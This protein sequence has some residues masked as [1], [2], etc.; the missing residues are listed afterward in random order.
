MIY[1]DNSAT[2]RPFDSVVEKMR[3]SMEE[4]YFNPS[5]MY[6]QAMQATDALKKARGLVSDALGGV[7]RVILTGGG[8]EADNLA[9]LGVAERLRGRKAGFITTAVEH[10]AVLECM[11]KLHDDGHEVYFAPVDASGVVDVDDLIAHVTDDT[12][13][14]SVM[15]VNNE[16]GALQPIE[17][18]AARLKE[19]NPR[20]LFHVDGVQ[21]FLRVPIHL[22]K[23]GV[24]LYSLSGHKIHGPKGVGALAVCGKVLLA[25]RLLGGGQEDGLRSGTENVPGIVGLS[26]AIENYPDTEKAAA[27]MQA[28]KCRLCEGILLAVPEA[29]LNGPDPLKGAPHILNL[30]FP[31]RGEVL[32]HALEGMGVLVSTGSACSSHKKAASHVLTAMGLEP[33]RLDGAVRFSLSVLNNEQEI[34]ETIRMVAQCVNSLKRFKRR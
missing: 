28:L 13:L 17:Q 15:Q 21:G 34:E 16:V 20:A 2:T 7:D 18:I 10:P 12:A 25:P 19:K 5:S 32:L 1:L 23:A 31:V 14:V 26:A 4:G 8:T 30:S 6:A 24:D 3:L 33:A 11:N 29:R 22:K 27:R 9:I